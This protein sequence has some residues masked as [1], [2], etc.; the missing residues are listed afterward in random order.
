MSKLGEH[1][2]IVTVLDT[3]EHDGT[4]YVVSEYVGGGDLAG[5][6]EACA[7]RRLEIDR[8]TAIVIDVCRA[9]E[10]AHSRGVVHRD[11]KPA[12]VWLGDDDAARLGDFGLATTDRRSRAAVEGM[13]VGTVSYLPPELALGR[14]ADARSD[15][16]SLGAMFYELLTGEPPFPGD[17][18]V[19]IIGQHLSTPPV[20]P[21]RHRDEVSPAIDEV[22]LRLLAKSPDERPQSA[23]ETRREIEAAASAPARGEDDADAENP[24]EAL[25]GGVFVGRDSEL[26]EARGVLEDALGGQG[27]LLLLSGDPGIGKTRTAEQLA[28]YAR[29]RGARVYWGRCYET[30][31]QPP[32]WP[33][34]EAIREY[35]LEADPVGLRWQL[36][37][38]AAEIARIVPELAERLDIEI[39]EQTETEQ[40]RFRLFDSVTAFLTDASKARPTVIVLD[41]LHWAD[42]PSLHLLSFVTRRFADSGLLL[43][44]TYRD[45]EL[46]RHHH[47]GLTLEDLAGVDCVRR[48]S[49][50]GLE[51]RAIAD[52][53]ELTA[54][55]DRPPAD[56]AQ[57]I[58]E[59]TGGNPFFIG[60]VVRL[61]AAE[62]HLGEPA[63]RQ[64]VLIPQGVRQ[65]VGRR[66]DRLS[67]T[68]NEVLGI[69]SIY[70]RNFPADVVEAVSE[71]A[72]DVVRAG[73]AEAVE[74]RLIEELAAD[75]GHYAFSHA[76]VRETLVAEIPAAK[77]VRLH[78]L[79]AEALERHT[80]IDPDR[81]L[82]ELAHH[83]LEAAPLGEV[84]RAIDYATRGAIRAAQ[85]FA[86]EDA[87]NLY[88]KA[89][90]TLEMAPPVDPLRRLDLRLELG[91]AQVR[92][93]RL[94][95]ARRT[96]ERGA[97]VARELDRPEDLARAALQ[98]CLIAVAGVVDEPL[99]SLLSEALDD[100]PGGRAASLSA[101]LR[102]RPDAVLGR[103]GR[104]F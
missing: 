102:A 78:G 5:V 65:V 83:F 3:G 75:P 26:G 57:A 103:P 24:L 38:R 74:S 35:V 29:V 88:E 27:R 68:A 55:V 94:V 80:D 64:E 18:A 22:V 77:R 23:A 87:A 66:L 32:Y 16:Y 98:I 93:G 89:L 58:A 61:M 4:P 15:L 59:Q 96:L 44:G 62:G 82:S 41:D 95:E 28:T 63:A 11:L 99:T 86:H 52:Y 47:L 90:E 72:P 91:T 40:A 84:D 46:G 6:L 60:E 100:R 49:L 9:L 73:L 21:S 71:R 81:H 10:H 39:P 20:A 36:G 14:A 104:A 43:V 42:E 51:P 31:G 33:W 69:A 54:G 79:I 30:K 53:I 67:E 25:A 8:A 70:G 45:V 13:L 37:A 12:N 92:A 19:A 48:V 50:R 1:P 85:R 2:H 17:D 34:S 97:T 76:L 7:G 101:A 56:L